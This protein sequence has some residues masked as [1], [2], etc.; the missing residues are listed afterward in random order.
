MKKWKYETHTLM[1]NKKPIT[2]IIIGETDNIKTWKYEEKYNTY[3]LIDNKKA[4]AYFTYTCGVILLR[5]GIN[6]NKAKIIFYNQTDENLLNDKELI[7][8]LENIIL[9]GGL[10]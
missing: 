7:N 2:H 5:Y 8:K 10:I 4:I 9:K 6:H 3:V 1:E